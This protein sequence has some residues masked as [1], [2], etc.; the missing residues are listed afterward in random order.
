MTIAPL[1]DA[2]VER[3]R[4][5]MLEAYAQAA[6]AFTSTAEE[7]AAEPLSWWLA[8][9]RD[10]TG[11]PLAWGAFDGAGL[12]G[13]VALALS[14]R[15]KTRHRAELI[16]MYVQPRARGAGVGR[17]LVDAAL[18]HLHGRPSVTAVALTVTQGNEPAI[19]LYR[20]AGFVECG[21]E[22]MAILTPGGY[23][24]KVRMWR[25]IGDA[26]ADTAWPRAGG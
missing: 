14:S 6:D 24:S 9:V 5:L 8:R 22:P 17:A 19:G 26:S 2:D 13:T 15:P 25:A 20:A 11:S 10:P 21:V 4:A 23:R 3:Y 12:V 16:G 18:A 7:R 1:V